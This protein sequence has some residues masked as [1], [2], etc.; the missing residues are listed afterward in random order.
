M[1]T[2]TITG[3]DVSLQE[4]TSISARLL[5]ESIVPD[6]F[7][8]Y[9]DYEFSDSGPGTGHFIFN[10][11]VEDPNTTFVVSVTDVD[12]GLVQW[13]AGTGLGTNQIQISVENTNT[14]VV[15]NTTSL[16]AQSSASGMSIPFVNGTAGDDVF[17]DTSSKTGELARP[18]HEVG[19][20]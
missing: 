7:G 10:G 5:V 11:K 3:Q 2:I 19:I 20:F 17:L 15:S 4:G 9:T 12:Q 18:I 6:S 8:T 13:V 16:F 1:T 14:G